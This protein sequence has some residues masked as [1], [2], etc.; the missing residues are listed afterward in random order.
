M[1]AIRHKDS[2]QVIRLDASEPTEDSCPQLYGYDK[3]GPTKG[4]YLDHIVVTGHTKGPKIVF[5][6]IHVA[7]HIDEN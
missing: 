4:F 3:N 2:W 6:V 1:V 5:L 7:H